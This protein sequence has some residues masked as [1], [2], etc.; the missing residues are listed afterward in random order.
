MINRQAS[1]TIGFRIVSKIPLSVYTRVSGA[2]LLVPYYHI[3][4]DEESLHVK[5]LYR[6]K[7]I[8]EFKKDLDF[9]AKQYVPLG[10]SE[11]LDYKKAGRP[12]PE[13]GLL[14]TFDDG[15]RE[16]SDIVAPIL[17]EKGIS[18]TFFVN[19]AFVDNKQLCYLNKASLIVEQ[20]QKRRSSCLEGKVCR[21]LDGNEM[22]F[23][24]TKSGVLSIQYGQRDMLD[25]IA[26]VLELDFT[27]YSLMNTPY[28]TGTQINKLIGSGFTIGA[29]S[30]DHPLYS[31]LSVDDQLYQTIESVRYVRE[32]FDLSYGVFAFPHSDHNVSQEFFDRVSQSGLIDLSFG[33]A[34]LMDDSVPN[35]LQRFSLEKPLG[36]AE[37]I[38][39]F[40]H[41]RR[42]LKL[43]RGSG[44]I[45]RA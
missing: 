17:L 13:R 14:L 20:L 19:S 18:A 32:T 1:K 38:V 6:Y 26:H 41:A 12:L 2:R 9:L 37:R 44:R 16:M 11:V 3:V 27:A 42:L 43:V 25:E 29:H 4:S 10:L 39:A 31:A 7:S 30:I 35:N 33:T 36:A 45:V 23:E 15:Y 21:I 28:L 8:R 24:D 34:G 5:H 40:Q 22:E